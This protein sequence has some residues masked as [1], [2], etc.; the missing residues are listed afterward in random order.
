MGVEVGIQFGEG[1]PEKRAD[2]VV[3]HKGTDEPWII[4][5]VKKP[6]R[7]DGEKQLKSYGQATGSPIA[8][9]TNGEQ[10]E[11]W[12]RKKPNN[13][14][15]ITNIPTVDQTLEQ[16]I[17]ELWT[18]DRLTKENKL[19]TEKK[20]LRDIIQTLEDLVLVNSAPDAFEEAFKL[21][22]TKLYD[23]WAATNIR[24]RNKQVYFRVYNEKPEELYE[25]INNLFH[26]AK[27]KWRDVFNEFDKIELLPEHLETCVSFLQDIKLFNSNL[28]V[29]D[30]A[31]EH[32]VTKVAKGEKGQ[33][34]TPRHVIDM[35]VKMLNPKENE[36]VIDPA[37]GSCGFTVHT[38]FHIM[39]NQPF[40]NQ[41]LPDHARE[42]AQNNVYGIDLDTKATKVAKALNL[43]AGD[44]KSNVYQANSLDSPA[45]RDDIRAAFKKYLTHFK[46]KPIEDENQKNFKSFD[47]DVLMTNPPF[48]GKQPESHIVRQ[49][50]L[51]KNKKGKIIPSVK[52]D[53]LFLE[54]AFSF[55]RDGGRF[56]IVLP[57]GKFNNT[58]EERIRKFIMER[59]RILA[60][61]GLDE[62][63]FRPHTGTKT[64][65][66]FVQKWHEDLCP[67]KDNY[68][69]FFATS[70]K[71]GKDSSGD[72]LFLRDKNGEII[73]DS[74]G[75]PKVEHDLD[76]TA[77]KFIE[78]ARQ[79]E[80][81]FVE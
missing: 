2:I 17:S 20:S 3:F 24:S 39:G 61:V 10:V 6:K 11:I 65:V 76:E 75:H 33:Y 68:P 80:L 46:E 42:F 73:L 66:L 77:D 7:K 63:T 14:L 8:V 22:Y 30:E 52:R 59:G 4:V 16:V 21:I 56:A 67:K 53:T 13:F 54:R 81:S 32:L 36:Y 40:T 60:V 49:Y 28:Y 71:T 41:K 79:E 72:Y 25:K 23:E 45:W 12:Y 58:K 44:G 31:F 26:D 29:I 57:Q 34:F 43:I 9:W 47:F 69:I 27:Q 70:Q 74:H 1:D 64:S 15:S 5:E 50:E 35:C 19:V 48:A 78:F 51:A 55:V 18:I 62:N 37:A 38:I